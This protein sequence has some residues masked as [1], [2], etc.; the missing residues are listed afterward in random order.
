MLI[1][2]PSDRQ[3]VPVL[4][5]PDQVAQLVVR[6][7]LLAELVAQEQP[8]GRQVGR[9]ALDRRG[10]RAPAESKQADLGGTAPVAGANC[11]RLFGDL[12]GRPG[13]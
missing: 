2:D 6:V 13:E 5:P 7:A 11:A 9:A 10:T 4:F 3:G 1:D 12:P 8:V